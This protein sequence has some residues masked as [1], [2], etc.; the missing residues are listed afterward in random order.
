MRHDVIRVVETYIDAVRRNDA[1]SLPLHPG[2]VFE[3][4][5]VLPCHGWTDCLDRRTGNPAI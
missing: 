4:P 5:R 3:S 2:V 1:D